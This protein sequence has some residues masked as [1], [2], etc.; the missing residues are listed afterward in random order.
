MY[1]PQFDY[2]PKF[3]YR[4]LWGWVIIV[5]VLQLLPWLG[6]ECA[7]SWCVVQSDQWPVYAMV[8]ALLA[9]F[10]LVVVFWLV[11]KVRRDDD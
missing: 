11:R 6:V 10:L 5:A 2:D 9:L 8:I 4:P 7:L 1:E 3:D